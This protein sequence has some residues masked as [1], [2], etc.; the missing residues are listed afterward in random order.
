MDGLICDRISR[1]NIT[2]SFG[3]TL[4]ARRARRR[5][6]WIHMQPLQELLHRITWDPVFG[7]GAFALGYEDRVAREEK[8]VPF[9]SISMDPERPEAFSFA[10]DEGIVAHI[11]LH[12]VRAVYKDGV[13]IWRRPSRATAS[14]SEPRANRTA[15]GRSPEIYRVFIAITLPDPVKDAIEQA[16]GQLRAALPGTCV[17]WARRDQLH[18]TLKFLGN[19]EVPRLDALTASIRSAC[20]GFG[21]LQLRAG[22]IG[23]FPDARHPRV[24]WT[25]V[26]D[27]QDRLPSLQRV[28]ETAAAEF[29][30]QAPAP[31]FTGHVTLGRCRAI[32]RSQA[33][34]LSTSAKAMEDRMFGEW[35]ADRLD[36]IR[37]LLS[38]TGSRYVTL[39]ALPLALR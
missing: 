37:S 30:S 26:R 21:A 19:V 12:R 10:D 22:Q 38:R 20:A 8:I 27:E 16:Q 32:T 35:A 4:Q 5:R 39:A 31:T 9:A 6:G 29:T 36:L 1:R 14:R 34:V 23:F 24:V 25:G 33:D 2:D 13:V 28:V 15:E 17:R 3:A 7:R 18:L 11:P